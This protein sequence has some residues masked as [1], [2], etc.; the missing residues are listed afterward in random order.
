[1]T[2]VGIAQSVWQQATSRVAGDRLS[3]EAEFL[4]SP[5]WPDLSG[6]AAH[7]ASYP[8]CTGGYFLKG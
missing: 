1:M 8:M 6:S 7:T 3:V 2:G 5:Q 4:S